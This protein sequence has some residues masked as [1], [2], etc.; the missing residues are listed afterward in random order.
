MGRP[1]RSTS[2]AAFAA[3]CIALL[4][5]VPVAATAG[6][7]TPTHQAAG[8]TSG[9][10]VS[11]CFTGEG[12]DL[13][14]GS[15]DGARIW[16][17][18]H[19]GPLT[20]SGWSIGAETVGSLEGQSIVEVV[21]GIEYVGDGFFDL[22]DDPGESFDLVSGFGFE[23]PMLQDV[24][25]GLGNASSGADAESTADNE[26]APEREE[27]ETAGNDGRFELLRC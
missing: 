25:T 20:G 3:C 9:Q 19:A 26:S 7:S 2:I 13:T 8:E 1:S 23:L 14:I 11:T 16:I 12:S 24:S 17:R 21:A 22:F 6:Q 15:D 27:R 5:V 10:S 18:F 4:A